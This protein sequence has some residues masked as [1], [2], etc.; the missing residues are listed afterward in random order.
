MPE[1][2]IWSAKFTSSATFF[3]LSCNFFCICLQ[4]FNLPSFSAFTPL[5]FLNHIAEQ[6]TS[7]MHLA[8]PTAVQASHKI[9]ESPFK[10][11]A[12]KLALKGNTGELPSPAPA[13]PRVLQPLSLFSTLLEPL[14]C[15]ASCIQ[16]IPSAYCYKSYKQQKHMQYVA[17]KH[18]HAN[19]Y[20]PIY[21]PFLMCCDQS[22]NKLRKGLCFV[23]MR[24]NILQVQVV[25]YQM[26]LQKLGS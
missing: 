24:W 23:L 11:K 2:L 22:V 15:E 7:H 20:E 6:T 21:L 25:S 12:Q 8:T 9:E 10:K 3:H 17:C 26:L 18:K 14:C 16:I 13:H 5:A 19:S 4:A 1:M